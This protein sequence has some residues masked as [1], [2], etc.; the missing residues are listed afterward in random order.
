MAEFQAAFAVR[1]GT[2][3]VQ[4]IDAVI[5]SCEQMLQNPVACTKKYDCQLSCFP[6]HGRG[7]SRYAHCCNGHIC[8]GALCSSEKAKLAQVVEAYEKSLDDPCAT[9]IKVKVLPAL[10]RLINDMPSSC[11]AEHKC[12]VC[13]LGCATHRDC[14]EWPE[15]KSVHFGAQHPAHPNNCYFGR[16][17]LCEKSHT[18][19]EWTSKT[20]DGQLNKLLEIC[21]KIKSMSAEDMRT[22]AEVLADGVF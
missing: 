10:G 2:A 18:C 9:M 22:A 21:N 13:C 16:K 6:S 1:A 8:G 17:Q 19:G 15:R 11:N 12:W 4:L 5:L 3:N 20:L 14:C 7:G